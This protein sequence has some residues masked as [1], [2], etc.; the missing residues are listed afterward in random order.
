M[1][2]RAGGVGESYKRFGM[3]RE[4]IEKGGRRAGRGVVVCFI[5]VYIDARRHEAEGARV[6]DTVMDGKEDGEGK[7]KIRRE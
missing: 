5:T 6:A 2:E 3:G 4:I 7:G 1:E